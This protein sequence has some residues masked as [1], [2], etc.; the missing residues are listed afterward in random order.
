MIVEWMIVNI[1]ETG[2]YSALLRWRWAVKDRGGGL[3]A[4]E[5]TLGAG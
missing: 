3:L 2:R 4:E 1:R 5:K